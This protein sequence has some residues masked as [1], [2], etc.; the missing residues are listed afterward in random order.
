MMKEYKG[1]LQKIAMIKHNSE[2][3]LGV[4][5][6]ADFTPPQKPSIKNFNEF[7]INTNLTSV[8]LV[9]LNGC[10]GDSTISLFD[11]DV[12]N[13][14]EECRGDDPPSLESELLQDVTNRLDAL[15]DYRGINTVDD[16]PEPKNFFFFYYYY[17]ITCSQKGFS[18]GNYKFYILQTIYIYTHKHTYIHTNTN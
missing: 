4:N 11:N 8:E 3:S 14:T 12:T 18:A 13:L 7:F 2:Y 9:E 1:I 16:K 5:N 17:N 10:H 6:L 15:S